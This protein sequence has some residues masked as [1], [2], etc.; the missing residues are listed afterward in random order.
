MTSPARGEAACRLVR[1]GQASD[2]EWD[3]AWRDCETATYFQSRQWAD[4]WRQYKRG[5][6]CPDA[7]RLVFSDGVAVVLPASR[8]RLLRGVGRRWWCSPMDTYGGWLSE[9]PLDDG[10]VAAVAEYVQTRFKAVSWRLNPLEH[11]CTHVPADSLVPDETLMLELTC[12]FDELRRGCAHGHRR[13]ARKATR[14][15]VVVR[16]AHGLDDWMAYHAVYRDSLRRWGSAS[17]FDA[18]LFRLLAARD[19]ENIV[20]WLATVDEEVVGGLLCFCGPR[21][22]ACWHS[23]V[24][25]S[26]LD[27]RPMPLVFLTAIEDACRRGMRW[28]DFNPSMGLSGVEEFKRR[29]GARS[30]PC[31]VMRHERGAGVRLWRATRRLRGGHAPSAAP[32]R[33]ESA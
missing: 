1:H 7:R 25:E 6:L 18:E 27:L 17:G 32:A 9:S 4:I 20:L 22:V 10:H 14:A 28:F 8:Q 12:G 5:A 15:G 19:D 21:H 30:V 26:A 33:G 2:A 3:E 31:P 24:L 13:A 23:S 29:F 16:S 11:A